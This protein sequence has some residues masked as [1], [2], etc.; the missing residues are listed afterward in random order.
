MLETILFWI[1]I[2]TIPM[3]VILGLLSLSKDFMTWLAKKDDPVWAA[4]YEEIE[5]DFLRLKADMRWGT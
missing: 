1:G 2:S 3:I 5:K 4:A